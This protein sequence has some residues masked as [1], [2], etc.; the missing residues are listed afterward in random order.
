M[1]MAGDR[2]GA[3]PLCLKNSPITEVQKSRSAAAKPHQA[4]ALAPE[5]ENCSLVPDVP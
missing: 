4:P 2:R 3:A 5:W 1:G